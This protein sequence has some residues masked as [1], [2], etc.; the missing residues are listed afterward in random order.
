MNQRPLTG[1][2]IL[3]TGA[4]GQ[5]EK[6]QAELE[7]LGASVSALPLI[8][9]GDPADF[10]DLDNGLLQLADYHWMIFASTNA[11]KQTLKRAR[12][13][14]I[15]MAA[16]PH[17]K[18]AAV[19]RSTAE[20]L[21]KNGLETTFCP[22]R[23]VAEAL[24]EEFPGYP[25]QLV[26]VKIF[27]PKTDIGRELI[28]EKFSAA[29]AS[30]KTAVAYKT[31]AAGDQQEMAGVLRTKLSIDKIDAITLTSA[32]AARNL[33]ALL[34]AIFPEQ[35]QKA[36]LAGVKI[37]VIGPATA[38]AARDCLGRVDIEAAEHSIPGLSAA[39]LAS[40]KFPQKE[41]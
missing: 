29:G 41:P 1:R 32:Q 13:L 5:A 34:N 7:P 25:D 9:I 31:T 6:F 26:G 3:V 8:A 11:V 18:I 24:I 27:L 20:E 15:D 33:C 28:S 14:G 16:Q 4:Q 38:A 22:S 37:A 12:F 2:K 35:D 10:R 19:G 17:L 36:V 30:V 39:L 23:F 21:S 40:L